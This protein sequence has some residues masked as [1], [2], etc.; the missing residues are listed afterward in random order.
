MT[1]ILGAVHPAPLHTLLFGSPC[2]NP[3]NRA[4]VYC[5]GPEGDQADD[6]ADFIHAGL[7]S[8]SETQDKLWVEHECMISAVATCPP[9]PSFDMPEV[10][11]CS[12]PLALPSGPPPAPLSPLSRAIPCALIPVPRLPAP[13]SRVDARMHF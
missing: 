1:K 10:E 12:L 13:P 8:P 11:S 6:A 2:S 7:I 5:V 4:M 3:A 9:L